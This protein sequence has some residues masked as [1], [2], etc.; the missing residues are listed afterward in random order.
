MS[1]TT[2]I[3]EPR[4]FVQ[5]LAYVDVPGAETGG[6][7]SVVELS[8]RE[9]DMPPLH[10]H[11]HEDEAFYVLDGRLTLFVGGEQLKLEA[12]ECAVAPRGVP[13]VYRVDSPEARWLG[14]ASPTF[15]EF[16]LEASVPAET[17]TIPDGPPAFS[18]SELAEIA[19]RHGIEVLGPPGMLP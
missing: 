4:W 12:G 13:H 6:A 10:V 8:G 17:A 16:V 9:G 1:T 7:Y 18:P 11:H 15:G 5:N 3:R 19:A 14:V 2:V